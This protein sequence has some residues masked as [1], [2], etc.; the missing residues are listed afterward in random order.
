[1]RRESGTQGDLVV[2]WA[3]PPR[4]LRRAFCDE[5][6]KLLIETEFDAFVEEACKPYCAPRVG[7]RASAAPLLPHVHG[8]TFS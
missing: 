7:A 4:W 8:R 6:Q 3:G 5:L 1:M 2:A